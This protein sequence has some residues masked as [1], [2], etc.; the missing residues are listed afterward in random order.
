M[1]VIY[2]QSAINLSNTLTALL[3]YKRLTRM[4]KFELFIDFPVLGERLFDCISIDYRTVNI[5]TAVIL[6]NLFL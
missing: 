1:G 5:Q 3:T 6:L 2:F 4:L